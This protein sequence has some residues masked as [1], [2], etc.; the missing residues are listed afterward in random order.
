[1]KSSVWLWSLDY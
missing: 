1:M